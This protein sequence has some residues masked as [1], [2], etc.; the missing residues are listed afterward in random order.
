MWRTADDQEHNPALKDTLDDAR[1]KLTAQGVSEQSHNFGVAA[2]VSAWEKL[3][4]SIINFLLLLNNLIS[5]F[6]LSLIS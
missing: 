2:V 6:S 3:H 1:C 4:N 5:L